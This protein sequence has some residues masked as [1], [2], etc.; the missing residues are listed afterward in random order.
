MFEAGQIVRTP[1][2]NIGKIIKPI[3]NGGSL[4]RVYEGT[5]QNEQYSVCAVLLDSG[6]VEH[7]TTSA[8]AG[9]P[10]IRRSG[11]LDS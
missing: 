7:W 1:E 8:L 3:T 5:S 2:G 6:R 10:D 4:V 11:A 9:A